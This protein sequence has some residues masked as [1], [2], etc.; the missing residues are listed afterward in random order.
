MKDSDGRDSV[1]DD[2]DTRSFYENLP[3]LA[4]FVPKVLLTDAG[5]KEEAKEDN[6]DKDEKETDKEKDEK[7]GSI[8]RR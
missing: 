2:E 1:W 6:K 7:E 3:D 8:C 5:H 4:L